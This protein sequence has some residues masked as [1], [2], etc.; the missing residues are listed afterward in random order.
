VGADVDAGLGDGVREQ[1]VGEERPAL[2]VCYRE[3][4]AVQG[5]AGWVG[6]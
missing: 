1:G 3:L 5:A 6:G 2:D 4:E